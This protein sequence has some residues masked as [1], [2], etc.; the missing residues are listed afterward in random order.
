MSVFRKARVGRRCTLFVLLATRLRFAFGEKAYPLGCSQK[1]SSYYDY[2]NYV[3]PPESLPVH[4]PDDYA[5]TRRLGTGK[6]SDVF[7]A[8]D[9]NL[10]RRVAANKHPAVVD[11]RTITVIKCLKPV[12]ERKIRREILVLER[13]CQLPNL[14]R[15][16]AVVV[17]PE[18]YANHRRRS[19]DLPRMPALVLQHA[20]PQSQWLCHAAVKQQEFENESFLTD[21]EI[22]YYLYHLL[23][24]LD[25]LHEVG[26]MHRDVKP[27]N[28]LINRRGRSLHAPLMLIDL[29]L[30]DFYHPNVSY[31]V[32]VA[33]RHYKAPELLIGYGFYDYA[34]DLWGVGCILAGLLWRREP[35]FR[36]KD[37]IDQLA[38]IISILGTE[39]LVAFVNE[40]QLE[41]SEEVQ[42][43]LQDSNDGTPR[44]KRQKRMSWATY[45]NEAHQTKGLGSPAMPTREAL[46][47]LD[48]LLVYDPGQR[49]TAK[50]AMQHPFFDVV[51]E[52]VQN[53]I[54]S[55]PPP[56]VP[57]SAPSPGVA[58]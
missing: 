55:Y 6:F 46:D 31:N 51:R 18:Y 43:E 37:N 2:E 48:H 57:R 20:G 34:I 30:A 8:V 45:R 58:P 28:V 10:E 36:G 11:P 19:T 54:R 39:D 40:H 1:P 33:S 25:G 7:E 47:L 52:R 16:I 13:A 35:F 21:Y 24:A 26:L 27:R 38:K 56:N 44:R 4:S 15:L 42:M 17:P 22:R 23:T 50:Q 9:I 14:A 49:W 3:F 32:R 53:E 5:L 41:L 12:S 29:G